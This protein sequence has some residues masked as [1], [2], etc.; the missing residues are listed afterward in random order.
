MNTQNSKPKNAIIYIRVSTEEQVENY[1]LGNQE[2][3]CKKE[4]IRRGYEVI[5]VFK[6]EGRSAKN[7]T[8]RPVLIRMLEYC[9]KNKK[10]ISALFV[11]RLDRVA[12]QTADYL[13][14]RKKLSECDINLISTSEP[15]GDSPTEKFVE[16]MMAGFAQMDND[17]RSE[18]S[19]N[20]LR[21][22]FLAGIY[23]GI[24]PIGYK[25]ENGYV[26]KN[27]ELFEKIQKSWELMGTGTKT[28]REIA[29]I[30]TYWGIYQTFKGKKYP[31]RLQSVGRLF[32]NKFYMGVLISE[33]H[34]EEVRGQHPPMVTEQLF[35]RVQAIL[36]GR[37][38][39]LAV[40]FAKRKKDNAD[41][42]LRK[43]VNCG[44][45]GGIFTGAWSKG[46]RIRY[47]YYFCRY[48]CTNQSVPKEE[49]EQAMINFLRKITPTPECLELFIVLLRRNYMKRITAL[50]KKKEGAD[51]E[52]S[53]LYTQRQTLIEKNLAG[54]YSDEVFKEQNAII[55][56]KIVAAR[57]TK[58]DTLLQKY[59]LEE[60]VKFMKSFFVDLGST[61]QKAN[62]TQK[63]ALLCS[64]IGSK[65]SWSYPGLA[66][67]EISP[68]YQAI[69][70]IGSKSVSLSAAGGSR[71]HTTLRPL[72]FKSNVY[73]I[74]P[75]RLIK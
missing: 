68:L 37:N 34:P 40:P 64:L 23:T 12:R 49:V 21:A 39:N 69:R 72:D 52:L 60:V 29:K 27:P 8:G 47:A 46:K 14:I 5:E 33:K 66:N 44:K 74:P 3:I 43:I 51:I 35:Y 22:R 13:V 25:N 1:S 73:T 59:N 67:T 4:A 48:R 71:T 20:G 10:N 11:Y 75:P 41:F 65:L 15:T 9:R 26:V 62:L 45:C 6:E 2:E 53:K 32:R 55:E 56:E 17:I 19:R 54:V 18:R 30:M 42:P 31:M 7:I 63:K 38:T 50:K 28:L 61:Y 24:A 57:V 36:D 58:D 70:D 16:T